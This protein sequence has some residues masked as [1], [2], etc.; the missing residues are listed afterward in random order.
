MWP[1]L[2]ALISLGGAFGSSDSSCYMEASGGAG[3]G[4]RYLSFLSRRSGAPAL[5][6]SAWDGHGHLLACT[7]HREAWLTRRYQAACAN[8]PPGTGSLFARS[9]SPARQRALD[10][11]ARQR[12]ACSGAQ[13]RGA[14]G[15]RVRRAPVGERA[16]GSREQRGRP[17]RRRGWT[18]P[19]TLWCGAGDSAESAAELGIFQ[20]PDLCCREHDQ[21]TAQ[22]SALEYNYGM[23]NYRLHTIS[24]CDCDARFRQCLLELNDTIS[25]IIGVTF[26]NLLE[27][28]CFVLEESEECVLWHWWGGCQHYGPVALARLVQQSQYHYD[29]PPGEPASPAPRPP[30]KGRK[31][32]KPGRKHRRKNVKGP[33]QDNGAQGSQKHREAQKPGTAPLPR[34][35]GTLPPAPTE[36]G[37]LLTTRTSPEQGPVPGT[38]HPP[39]GRAGAEGAGQPQDRDSARPADS[40]EQG[41]MPTSASEPRSTPPLSR[42]APARSCGCYRRLDQCEYKIAP[43]EVKYQLHNPDSRTLFHCNCTRRLVRFLRRTKGPNEVEE[44]VLSDFISAGCFVLEPPA[45]CAAGEEQEPNC[46]GAGR[47]VLAP[48]R[49]LKNTLGWRHQRPAAPV[50]VKRQEW[51]AQGGPLRLYEKCLQLARAARGADHHPAPH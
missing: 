39:T 27:A 11:L 18:M 8:P 35:L 15:P 48:A 45:G 34:D 46:S 28:P 43:H 41:A 44:E 25:N 17:R 38:E 51:V 20:G 9:W 19:G 31:H 30:G 7:V 50:K 49:H 29:P 14:G 6:Q 21:C 33:K 10:S 2:W 12:D 4:T 24:H 22:L 23:R 32:S 5:Y 13:P 36:D 47:A 1:L 16:G 42:Q 26:F 3:T 40:T 37:R